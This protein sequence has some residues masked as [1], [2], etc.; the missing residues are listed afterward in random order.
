MGPWAWT[1]LKKK[2]K[3]VFKTLIAPAGLLRTGNGGR[4][5]DRKSLPEINRSNFAAP[6]VMQQHSG[7][8]TMN[9]M[10]I[11]DSSLGSTFPSIPS[12]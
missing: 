5:G 8:F 6:P 12:A 10:L 9:D 4:G 3:L 11:S 1:I 2:K 7:T